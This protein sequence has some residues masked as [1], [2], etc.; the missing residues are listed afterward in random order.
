MD[1]AIEELREALRSNP[2]YPEAHYNLGGLLVDRGQTEEAVVHYKEALRLKP[3]YAE[4]RQRL[5]ELGV[6][7]PN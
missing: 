3:D 2:N 4:A 1:A 6:T 5:L 7:P